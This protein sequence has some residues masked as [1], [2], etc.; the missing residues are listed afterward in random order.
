MTYQNITCLLGDGGTGKS[1]WLNRIRTGEFKKEYEQTG[2]TREHVI[3]NDIKIHTIR[4]IAGRRKRSPDVKALKGV[5]T[6]I[7]F[8]TIDSKLSQRNVKFWIRLGLKHSPKARVVVVL[9]KC[10]IKGHNPPKTVAS[11]IHIH[12][13]SKD[14][15]DCDIPLL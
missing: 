7:I 9:A 12:I 2:Q 4:D 3:T 14:L 8:C 5:N 15:H 10:D 11:M 13:S 6:F 1:A